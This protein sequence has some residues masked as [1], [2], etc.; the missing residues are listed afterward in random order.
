MRSTNEIGLEKL[1]WW[2]FEQTICWSNEQPSLT[3]P[4][5]SFCFKM[6]Y[7]ILFYTYILEEQHTLKME[8]EQD[9]KGTGCSKQG[10]LGA[11]NAFVC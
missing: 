1:Q 11:T 8:M 5:D 9:I 6:D 10:P 7:Q 4:R 3:T 2:G